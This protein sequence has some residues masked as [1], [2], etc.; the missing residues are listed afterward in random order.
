MYLNGDLAATLAARNLKP[1]CAG[2]GLLGS[3]VVVIVSEHVSF[4]SRIGALKYF[5]H[6]D[7]WNIGVPHHFVRWAVSILIIKIVA[8]R[9]AVK[10]DL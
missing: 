7:M 3:V 5:L 6:F 2:D 10:K 8:I 9:L 1:H 4:A